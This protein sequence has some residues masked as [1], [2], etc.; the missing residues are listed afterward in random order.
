MPAKTC[1]ADSRYNKSR[2]DRLDR[3]LR[4]FPPDLLATANYRENRYPNPIDRKND[5]KGSALRQKRL[6]RL[7]ECCQGIFKQLF[8]GN[9]PSE[10]FGIT[11]LLQNCLILN[12]L[13]S[14]CQ[15]KNLNLFSPFEIQ[16]E[17]ELLAVLTLTASYINH[18]EQL[19]L[20]QFIPPL[21]DIASR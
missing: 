10:L 21:H 8:I 12:S 1:Q 18:F 3:P 14:Q 16:K 4:D 13:K 15:E 17:I 6:F 2:G 11:R 20:S 5:W 7:L 9:V 19:H